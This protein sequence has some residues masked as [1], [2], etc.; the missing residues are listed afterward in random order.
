MS[1]ISLENIKYSLQ[2][3]LVG[4]LFGNIENQT[5]IL[6]EKDSSTNLK[7]VK[8][9]GIPDDS[10]LIKIDYGRP[11]EN[12]RSEHGQR[13]R[14]DYLLITTNNNNK[15]VLLFVEMKSKTTNQNEI[16]QKF[17]ASECL[18]DYIASMLKHFHDTDFNPDECKK[19]FI[20]FQNKRLDKKQIHLKQN[21]SKPND[22]I[23]VKFD[24]NNPPTLKSLS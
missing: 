12:F 20:I 14:C 6:E 19:R 18:L 2:K 11:C 24:P 10:I 8:I 3:L 1:E 23:S 22:Y 9:V 15:K 13:K 21:G 17:L 16:V 4:E 5:A 7:N